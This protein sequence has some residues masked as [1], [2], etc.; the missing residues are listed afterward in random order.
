MAKKTWKLGEDAPEGFAP[1][2]V[3]AEYDED[4]THQQEKALI[5]AGWIEAVEEKKP[6]G[7][8]K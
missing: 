7:G 8:D 4:Y 6:K 3:G 2:E 5:A 1:V